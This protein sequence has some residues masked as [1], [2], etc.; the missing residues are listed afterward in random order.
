MAQGVLCTPAEQVDKV[1]RRLCI[2]PGNGH[3][4]TDT[5]IFLH[6]FGDTAAGWYSAGPPTPIRSSAGLMGG[7]SIVLGTAAPNCAICAAHRASV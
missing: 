7:G 4:H 1:A 3:S 2:G 5:C 6:G